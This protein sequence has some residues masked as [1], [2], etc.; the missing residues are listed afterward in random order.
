MPLGKNRKNQSARVG[1]SELKSNIRQKSESLCLWPYFIN[2]VEAGPVGF[3]PQREW[4]CHPHIPFFLITREHMHCYS[5]LDLFC[6]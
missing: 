6:L 3:E 5:F 4:R 1:S 2:N